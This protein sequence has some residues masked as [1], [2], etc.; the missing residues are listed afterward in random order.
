MIDSFPPAEVS[1]RAL[2]TD[3]THARSPAPENACLERSKPP[4]SAPLPGFEIGGSTSPAAPRF[5][6]ET[7]D[8]R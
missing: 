3:V 8:R 4:G 1:S 5:G 7:G 6:D 2:G